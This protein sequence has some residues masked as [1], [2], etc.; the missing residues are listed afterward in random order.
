MVAEQLSLVVITPETHH[1]T[2]TRSWWSFLYHYY[3]KVRPYNRSYL[4]IGRPE[5]ARDTSPYHRA[6]PLPCPR[7]TSQNVKVTEVT[8]L[9][10]P[11]ASIESESTNS[12]YI[13]RRAPHSTS[14]HLPLVSRATTRAFLSPA[15]S[16]QG[17]L[18]PFLHTMMLNLPHTFN[19]N[20]STKIDDY[21]L[22]SLAIRDTYTNS[23]TTNASYSASNYSI[24]LRSVR[25]TFRSPPLMEHHWPNG[26]SQERKAP[27]S[28]LATSRVRTTCHSTSLSS[29]DSLSGT[30]PIGQS[31]GTSFVTST[32]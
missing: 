26:A 23:P 14:L 29:Q 1:L 5:H 3:T 10:R 4:P 18:L 25:S 2:S 9:Y 28:S 16:W 11:G 19:S 15:E 30:L 13:P 21:P 32:P 22:A 31:Q 6:R 7:A 8:P 27:I 20:L 17:L 12:L 24:C